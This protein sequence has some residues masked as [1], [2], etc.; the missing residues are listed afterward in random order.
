[1]KLRIWSKPSTEAGMFTARVLLGLVW[2]PWGIACF[3]FFGW[4]A[5][6]P[7]LA[8]AATDAGLRLWKVRSTILWMPVAVWAV[9]LLAVVMFSD[10]A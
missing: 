7:F 2:I 1:M 8:I 5:Y 10:S 4:D 6:F 3:L 9:A